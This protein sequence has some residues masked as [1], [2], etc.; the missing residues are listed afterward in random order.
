MP[1]MKRAHVRRDW[2]LRRV[3]VCIITTDR[4]E[5]NISM[6]ISYIPFF[7]KQLVYVFLK[8]HELKSVDLEEIWNIVNKN[9][10]KTC[11]V[12]FATPSTFYKNRT[13]Q[14]TNQ[15]AYYFLHI[16]QNILW[17]EPAHARRDCILRLLKNWRVCGRYNDRGSGRGNVL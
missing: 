7:S 16:L 3:V 17:T 14:K 13:W 2:M 12:S 1:Q 15:R 5:W 6:R 8:F 10:T 9:K 11:H 4:E